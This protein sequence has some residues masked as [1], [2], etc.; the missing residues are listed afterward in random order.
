ME[1][2]IN[3]LGGEE[4]V[5]SLL[6][7]SLLVK[8]LHLPLAAPSV[9]NAAF[10]NRFTAGGWTVWMG[11]LSGSGTSGEFLYRDFREDDFY[12]IDWGQVSFRSMLRNR[13]RQIRL[14]EALSRLAKINDAHIFL[15]MNAFCSLFADYG[16]HSKSG[17]EKK[18]ILEQV[19]RH[20]G[21][22]FV[23]FAGIILRSPGDEGKAYMPALVKGTA[24]SGV[25]SYH[26]CDLNQA[27]GKAMLFATMPKPRKSTAT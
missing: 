3:R 11:P 4:G 13:E 1:A 9:E 5:K 26:F 14:S 20:K 8:R 23:G 15:G 22:D 7:G 27:Y 10:I 21:V 12:E 19:Y 24:S 2:V 17:T 25:W 6:N 18:S 16:Q